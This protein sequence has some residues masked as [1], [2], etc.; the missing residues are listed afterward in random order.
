MYIHKGSLNNPYLPKLQNLHI[1]CIFSDIFR[2]QIQAIPSSIGN[3]VKYTVG[4][5]LPNTI[6]QHV[7][8]R[9]SMGFT[10]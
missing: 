9:V 8:M 3:T 2:D 10:D 1:S 4:G 7:S 6:S 5:M